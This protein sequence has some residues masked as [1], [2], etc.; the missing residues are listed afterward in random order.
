MRSS[1][2]ANSVNPAGSVSVN[3]CRGTVTSGAA[4]IVEDAAGCA[5]PLDDTRTGDPGLDPAGLQD[6]G[7]R[8][9]TIALLAG[10][11]AIDAG[12]NPAALTFDQR[13]TPFERSDGNGTDV[14]AFER[15]FVRVTL[16]KALVPASDPGRFDLRVN[17]AV[18]RTAAANG[19]GGS[20]ATIVP[21]SDVTVT[22]VAAAGTTAADYDT[23]IDCGAGPQ[24]GT[25]L[26]LTNVTT[27]VACTITNTR[28]ASP[29]PPR[30]PPFVP[31]ELGGLFTT[32][33]TFGSQGATVQF[34]LSKEALVTLIVERVQV[35][36]TRSGRCVVSGAE[37]KRGK[38]CVRYDY[39]GKVTVQGDAGV[40]R[41]PFSGFLDNGRLTA[42]RYRL[43][44]H[45]FA[46]PQHV[47][48]SS[49]RFRLT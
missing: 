35:G 39:A 42:G 41:Y 24:A 33:K 23:T 11:P 43:T 37:R 34:R 4:N 31:L 1:I 13:G 12:A 27:D 49:I 9:R 48:T 40:N 45:A 22:E 36:R 15:Q 25:S 17:A 16:M 5:R 8:T 46:A 44:A 21:G 14:G 20:L 38:R 18:V 26:T 10:S 2:A 32:P 7:G 29:P 6:N 3:D 47:T 28:K 30:P 19:D